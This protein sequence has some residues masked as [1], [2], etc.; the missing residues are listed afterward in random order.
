MTAA[1]AAAAWRYDFPH[2]RKADAADGKGNPFFDA[3]VNQID[4]VDMLS[5]GDIDGG[6]DLVSILN[7]RKLQQIV[8]GVLNFQGKPRVR[9]Y[10]ADPL[11]LRLS[12]GNLRGVPYDIKMRGNTGAAHRVVTHA[13]DIGFALTG[14]S[15]VPAPTE[16]GYYRLDLENSGAQ[17]GWQLLGQAALA[18]GAFPFFLPARTLHRPYGDYLKRKFIIPGDGTNDPDFGETR[19]VEVKPAWPEPWVDPYASCNVDGGVMNNEPIAL[20]HS[21]LADGP[22]GRNPRSGLKADRALLMI[23]PFIEM[24]ADGPDH[25]EQPL[26]KLLLPLVNAWIMQCRFGAVDVGLAKEE[27]IYSRFLIAP[28]RD[29]AENADPKAHPLAAGGLGGFLGFFDRSYREHAYLLGRRNCQKFLRDHFCLPAANPLFADWPQPLRDAM[30][31][32]DPSGPHLP[33][34]PL[35][36]AC[37][38]VEE[39]PDYPFGK[40]S[41]KGAGNDDERKQQVVDALEDV[42][43]GSLRKRA[44]AVKDGLLAAFDVPHDARSGINIAWDLFVRRKIVDLAIGKVAD[45]IVAQ[46]L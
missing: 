2:I 26:L 15:D 25:A 40:F 31:I 12:V 41:S 6:G 7:G 23:D 8:E 43:A 21:V 42:L 44:N 46:K 13:D 32:E 39:I 34:I 28:Q 19:T 11:L 20:A 3:W 1:I 38:S 5:T 24:P 45:A 33:I 14:L 35:W 9:P 18:S 37:D 17:I 4:I 29:P 22:T 10:L 30:L 27:T 16:P 36:G